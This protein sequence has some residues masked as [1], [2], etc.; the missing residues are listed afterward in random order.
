M[1]ER[2]FQRPTIAE[3]D[4][5]AL[6]FNLRSVRDFVGAEV[7]CMAVVKANAYGHGAV[8][9]AERLE[10]AGVDWFGVAT[11]EEAIELRASGIVTP[12]LCLGG[13]WPGQE[14][15]FIESNITPAVFSVNAAADMDKTARSL[16]R[17]ADVHVKIDTGMGRVGVPFRG[18]SETAERLAQLPNVRVQALMTH[19]AAA[20]DLTADFTGEQTKRFFEAV[21]IF[22]Q[23]GIEPEFIDLANSP[24]AVGHPRSRANMV[25]LGGVLYGLGGDVLPK[26]IKTPELRRVMSI[27]T[28]IAQIK[29]IGAGETVGYGR[30]FTAERDTLI[31]TIPIGYHDGYRRALSNRGQVLIN[32]RSAPIAGRISMDWTTIVLDD[33]PEVSVGDEVVVIGRSG[34]SEIA[35]ED[36]AGLIGTISYEITC[37]ISARVPRLAVAGSSEIDD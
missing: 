20:D 1:A 30:T 34:R 11:L 19:F 14:A 3:I 25:R 35:A 13:V 26:G 22:Q 2:R 33:I 10:K 5:E 21:R 31:G 28:R 9:C 15:I 27:K 17:V 32:G 4:L 37:G 7:K 23:R 16:G 8:I 29:T 24:G 36:L 18:V 6:T 12:I